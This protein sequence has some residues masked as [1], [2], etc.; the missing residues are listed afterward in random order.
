MVHKDHVVKNPYSYRGVISSPGSIWQHLETLLVVTLAGATDFWWGEARDAAL[1]VTTHG[2]APPP[3]EG[4]L[5]PNIRSVAAEK[6]C[7][8]DSRHCLIVLLIFDS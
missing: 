2:T 8:R 6:T 4:D 5:A 7:L 1:Y 3:P